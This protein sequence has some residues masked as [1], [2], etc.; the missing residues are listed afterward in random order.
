[1]S[2]SALKNKP[3]I[4][5]P[6]LPSNILKKKRRSIFQTRTKISRIRD[7]HILLNA[8]E[9]LVVYKVR[10]FVEDDVDES[11]HGEVLVQHSLDITLY[12]V[13][14]QMKSEVLGLESHAIPESFQTFA[15]RLLVGPIRAEVDGP[16]AQVRARE[17]DPREKG[18]TS[19]VVVVVGVRPVYARS[20]APQC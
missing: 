19:V 3:R 18:P 11:H 10:G 1:M 7:K 16:G 14:V 2:D 9:F 15:G 8:C 20:A 4:S 17:P 6:T 5:Q 13:R 12:L